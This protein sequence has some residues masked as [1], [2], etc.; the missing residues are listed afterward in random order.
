MH[1]KPNFGSV[2][3]AEHRALRNISPGAEMTVP[4]M[5]KEHNRK[6]VEMI[7]D[8]MIQAIKMKD[9]RTP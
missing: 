6:V 1:L 8:L 2:T 3:E 5:I 4:D 9:P 7:E